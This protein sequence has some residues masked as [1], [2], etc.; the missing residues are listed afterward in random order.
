MARRTGVATTDPDLN[1][2]AW[3]RKTPRRVVLASQSAARLRL[4]RGAGL[5]PEVVVSGVAEDID[6]GLDTAAAVV[7]LAERKASTVAGRRPGALVL[8][9]DSMLDLDGVALGKPTS[10]EEAISMWRCL[11]GRTATLHTGHCLVD[12]GS[13]RHISDI[14]RTL[15]RF[16][17]P[18]AAEIGAYVASG[19]P[20]AMAG[21]FSIDGLGAPFVD[22]IDGDPTNVL[23]LSLPLLRRML[24]E[25][26]LMITDLWRKAL[27]PDV[28]ELTDAD[29]A[30]L[31]DLISA[32]WRLPVVS[33]SGAHDPSALS[34]LVAD[35]DGA[36]IG[37]LTYR[38]SPDGTEVV[39]LNSLIH[40]RGVGSALLAGARRRAEVTGRRLWLIT[41]NENVRAIAFYQRR[42]MDMVALHRNFA[43]TVRRAKPGI[44]RSVRGAIAFRHAIE[45]EYPASAH[46][47][48]T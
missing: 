17:T 26:G 41:T 10:A 44:D 6:D 12:T 25:L 30:W 43:E 35:Q 29:R 9:C 24:A 34:G 23:G 20:M 46:Q 32:E 31:R 3:T 14:A 45:F 38:D 42:G 27:S 33:V 19:E 47:G 22:G 40:D 39:T 16:G 13:G 8:G 11:S 7:A 28:R 4:M 18:S 37:A 5:D 2:Q 21:A 15:V 48:P 36:L 1:D